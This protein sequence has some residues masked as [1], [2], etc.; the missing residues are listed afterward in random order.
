MSQIQIRNAE[1]LCVGT[2]ILIGDIVNTNAA[3]ISS[4]LY[5]M[6]I[7]QYYQASIGDNPERLKNAVKSALSRCDL[8]IMTGGLG[9]TYDDLTKETVAECMNRKL[10]LDNKSLDSIKSYFDFRKKKMTENNVKQAMIPEGSTVFYNDA[11]TAPGLAVEDFENGKIVIMMPGVPFEMKRMFTNSVIPYLSKYLNKKFFSKNINI[12]GMGESEVESNLKELMLSSTNPTVAPYCGDGEVRLRVTAS[13]DNEEDCIKMCD[14]M[15]NTIRNTVVGPYIYGIDTSLEE[16]VVKRFKEKGKTLSVTESCTGGLISKRITDISGSSDIL[17]YGAVTYSNDAKMNIL[18]VK[19]ETLDNYTAVSEQ[20]AS[21]MA[22]G[23]RKLSCSDIS[24][25]TTGYAGPTG[26]NI[27]L[28]YIG[29]SSKNGTRVLK[30]MLKGS[31][32]RIR[33]LAATY[34]LSEVLKELDNI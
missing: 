20:T 7:N 25:S 19:K 6:G 17:G 11:G 8:L 4:K 14:D 29:I 32:D 10:Y 9:P 34:A 5:E 24:V 13:S 2:E 31:R 30:L 15:I 22:E 33:I 26:E 12:T 16:A 21:E 23:I 28:V 27:G 3:F 18:G 1:I